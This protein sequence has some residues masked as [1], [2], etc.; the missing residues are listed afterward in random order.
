M[1]LELDVQDVINL[2][3]I[4]FVHP[5]YPDWEA[6]VYAD[7]QLSLGLGQHFARC[8]ND[9]SVAMDVLV[10]TDGP[11]WGSDHFCFANTGYPAV[12]GID[13]QLWG[14]PDW[15]P[16]YHT[17]QERIETLDLPYHTE[18]VRGAAAAVA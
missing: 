5:V 14:A 17:A 15:D 11:I 16:Y 9:Y 1:P 18:C 8:I 6:N 7:Q 3:M 4:T 10:E 13:A 12:F 2:D